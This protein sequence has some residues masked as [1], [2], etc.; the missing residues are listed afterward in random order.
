MVASSSARAAV[1]LRV[2]TA[3]ATPGS[4]VFVPVRLATDTNIVAA[5]FDLLFASTNLSSGDA[6]PGPA[7]ADHLISS[8]EPQ[9]GV[10]RVVIYSP[11][12]ATLGNGVL[13][14][15]P[16]TVASNAP[17]SLAQLII[18]NVLCVNYDPNAV[19]NWSVVPGSLVATSSVAQPPV[20]LSQPA[21]RTLL[22]GSNVTLQV[23]ATGT[24]PL[25]YQWM[26]NGTNLPD[27]TNPT[28]AL[29]SIQYA[30]AGIYRV[31]VSNTCDWEL[32]AAATVNVAQPL[33]LAHQGTGS[34]TCWPS[35]YS[36]G[37]TITLSA[38]PGR[39]YQF[40]QWADGNTNTPRAITIGLTNTYTAIFSPTQPLEQWT[41]QT[42]G[43]TWEV[44]AGT[45]KVLVNGQLTFG[46]SFSLPATNGAQFLVELQTS[47]PNGLI[48]YTLDGHTPNWDSSYY[49][50]PFAVTD[51]A[52]LNAVAFDENFEQAQYADPVGLSLIPFYNLTAVS[53]GGGTIS[54]DPLP[55]ANGYLSNL[56]VTLTAAASNGWTFLNWAGDATGT[57]PAVTLAMNGPKSVQAIFGTVLTNT[58]APPGWGSILREPDLALYPYGSTVRL[59]AVPGATN[60]FGR[61]T[62][63]GTGLSNSPI[64]FAVTMPTNVGALFGSLGANRSLTVLIT[65]QGSVTKT[66]QLAYYTNG[67]AV[68][69]TATPSTHY[70]FT[71]WSSDAGGSQNPLAVTLT[72]NQA[73]TANFASTFPL[74]VTQPQSQAVRAGSN[75]RFSVYATSPLPQTCQWRFKGVD[76]PGQTNVALFLFDVQTGDAGIYTVA[77][78]NADG[79]TVSTAAVLTVT[80]PFPN[81]TTVIGWGGNNG[82]F[83]VAPTTN[84][85]NVKAI[86]V[87]DSVLALRND[88]NVLTWGWGNPA[89]PGGLSN[90]VSLSESPFQVLAL[91]KGGRVC[92]WGQRGFDPVTPPAG[93]SNVVKV[94][95]AY[96][97]CSLALEADGTVVGWGSNAHGQLSFPPGLSNVIDIAVGGGACAGS[98]E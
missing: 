67:Q 14:T 34:V 77:V 76:L 28:L 33:T 24:L 21:S 53:P 82:G 37:D 79:V 52:V 32:S 91:I 10:R 50:G 57:N 41:N 71:G 78:A 59:S 51:P 81:W 12:N 18:T 56:V 90:V 30:Q 70:Y 75:V 9:P 36:V 43:Q 44:P 68:T 20:I 2:G 39:W 31:A 15:V 22:F 94:A 92:G 45:P 55:S 58:V 98:Q 48:F 61:W 40:V 1:E 85:T 3:Y 29:P 95:A 35:N 60:Y 19:T 83:D 74:I 65:G 16:L 96:D 17:Y 11:T 4:T 42:S 54:L 7:L 6:L 87:H 25:S 62:G 72:M 13:V 88:G 47:Y 38:V 84:L 63:A 27:A 23:S 26:L 66:P 86:P 8:A 64:I 97:P 73:I 69:L 49:E 89:L 80:A 93:L 5:Q 46:G